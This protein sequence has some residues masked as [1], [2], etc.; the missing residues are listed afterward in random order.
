MAGYEYKAKRCDL[1]LH[2][3]RENE[4][5]FSLDLIRSFVTVDGGL[6]EGVARHVVPATLEEPLI[7]DDFG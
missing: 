1:D 6:F 3:G 5:G 2:A 4:H 7:L